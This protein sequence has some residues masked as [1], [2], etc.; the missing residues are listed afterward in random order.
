L[1]LAN[2][3]D[4]AV[5]KVAKKIF[6]STLGGLF[7]LSNVIMMTGGL[8]PVGLQP[9]EAS[10]SRLIGEIPGSGIFFKDILNV[11]S[12]DDPK[13]KASMLDDKFSVV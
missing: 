2:Q 8:I 13:V 10:D 5:D 7:I 12:F 4:G 6:Q 1:K 9:A 11:E 3:G